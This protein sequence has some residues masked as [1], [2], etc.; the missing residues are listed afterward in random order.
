MDLSIIDKNSPLGYKEWLVH[1]SNILPDN[2]S[3]EY[4]LYL[5][6]WYFKNSK[7]KKEFSETLRIEYVQLLKDLSFLFSNDEVNLFISQLD[8]NNDEEII[9]AIP[10]FAKKLKQIALIYNK[11]RESL[12]ESKL[13]YNLA[14]SNYGIEKLLYDY[15]L[16]GFTKN[17]S[18]LIR[19]PSY[20]LYNSFP[21]L[22]SITGDFF[23]EIEELYDKNTYFDS[24][25]SL[26]ITDYVDV[27]RFD[28]RLIPE[29]FSNLSD[30]DILNIIS[31]KFLPK[32]ST[33][34]L[35]KI[36]NEFLSDIPNITS[37]SEYNIKALNFIN[38]NESSKKYLGQ[39]V[40]GLT[41]V[42]LKDVELYDKFINLDLNTGNNWFY[43]PS[44]DRILNDSIFNNLYSEILLNDSNLIQSGATGGDSYTN[45]DLIFTDKSGVVE[46]AWLRGVHNTKTEKR[47]MI[48][49]IGSSDTKEF[50]FPYPG[51]GFSPKT[52]KFNEYKLTDENNFLLNRFDSNNKEQILTDYFT[53]ILPTSSCNS[54]YLNNTTLISNG[55]YADT[56][57]DTADNIIKKVKTYNKLANYDEY[58]FG[59]V[60]QAYLYKFDKT[61]IIIRDGINNI[62]WPLQNYSENPDIKLTIGLDHSNPIN[63]SE[64][65][66]AKTMSGAVA[67]LD[68]QTGDVIYKLNTKNSDPIEA[69]WLGSAPISRLDT[70]VNPIKIY[71]GNATKC[72]EY[73]DGPIQPALSIKID[74]SEKKSFIWMDEDTYADDVF[75]NTEHLPS[76]PYVKN[77]PYDY[78]SDQDYQNANPLSDIKYW[79]KCNCKALQYS[80]IGHSGELVTDYNG[81]A[82][83]L[84][85]DPDGMGEDFN[86]KGWAD[87]RNLTYKNSPQFSFYKLDKNSKNDIHVGWGS[88]SWKTGNGSKMVLKTG[89]RYT[90]YRSTLRTDSSDTPYLITIYK[91]NKI[92]GLLTL[93]DGFDLVIVID[94]S[95]SQSLNLQTTKNCVKKIID[96]LLTNNTFENIQIG[97]ITFGF[98]ANNV[99]FLSKNKNSLLLSI[100]SIFIP[101]EPYLSE[102]DITKALV[103]AN[104][105]LTETII[106]RESTD[107]IKDLC[108]NLNFKIYDS[109]LGNK[110]FNVP[111]TNKPKKIL[112]FSDGYVEG[113]R[114]KDKN[115]I[116]YLYDDSISYLENKLNSIQVDINLTL[117]EEDDYLI[118]TQK[119]NQ[120][121]EKLENEILSYNTELSQ[122]QTVQKTIDD[123]IKPFENKLND[124]IKKWNENLLR[125]TNTYTTG[126]SNRITGKSESVNIINVRAEE[127]KKIIN[128]LSDISQN[129]SS[130]KTI[131]EL[132]SIIQSTLNFITSSYSL[133][134]KVI[135]GS[136]E[137][138]IE[139]FLDSYKSTLNDFIKNINYQT[140]VSLLYNDNELGIINNKI[141]DLKNMLNTSKSNLTISK[142]I[143]SNVDNT[144][145]INTS[146]KL[147]SE[148]L[149]LKKS[150]SDILE[151][152]NELKIF[153]DQF[154][155][156]VNTL[157]KKEIENLKKQDQKITFYT[158]DI[159]LKSYNT[160]IMEYM[161]ST[162]SNYFNLQKYLDYGDG[163]INSFISYMSMRLCG[164]IPIIPIWYK[165]KRDSFGSWIKCYDEIGNLEIS[166]MVLS[167]GDYLAYIHRSNISYYSLNNTGIDFSYSSISFSINIKLNGWDYENH[168]FS[169]F[170]TG[171]KYGAKPYWGEVQISPNEINNF[172]KETAS[173][174][175]KIKF[176]DDY[177]P[178]QQPNVSD[179][180]IDN[181]CVIE[182]VRNNQ[183]ELIWTQPLKCFD[184]DNNY[185]WNKL[186]FKKDISNLED[187]LNK[188]NLDG[189]VIESDQPS[190]LI[191][192]GYSS[193]KPVRYNYYSRNFFT[194]EQGLNIKNKC[195]DSFY[196]YNTGV[197]IEPTSPY[198][199]ILN[200]HFPTIATIPLPYD[201]VKIKDTGEYLLP[202]NLGVSY[203]R[204]RGYN[205]S[206]DNKS[207]DSIDNSN[208]E[209]FYFN[210]EKYGPRNRGLTKKDQKTIVK[211]DSIDNSWIME[212]YSSAEKSGT[213]INTLE[214]QKMIPYQTSYEIDVKN[215]YG[216]SR[217]DDNFKFWNP[218]IPA[219]WTEEDSFPLTY[220]KEL[221]KEVFISRKNKLL[222]DAGKLNKW[223][224]DIFGNDYGLYKK[225]TPKD[226]QNLELWFSSDYG[227]LSNDTL[228]LDATDG[229]KVVKWLNQSSDFGKDLFVYSGIPK[230]KHLGINE[231]PSVVFNLSSTTDVMKNTY[232]LNLNELTF[233]VIG[234]SYNY[235]VPLVECMVSFGDNISN[236]IP[237]TSSALTLSISSNTFGFSFGNIAELKQVDLN[238]Q[239][240]SVNLTSPHI[241][242]FEFKDSSC[243]SYIDGNLINSSD[244]ILTT[245]VY[246]NKGLF[247]GSYLNGLFKSSCEISEIILYSRVLN[248]IEKDELYKYI[249]YKYSIF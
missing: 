206:I 149:I 175:G 184:I 127:T 50:I 244:N 64:I 143:N 153:V 159:G 52:S 91:Y 132:K 135:G 155:I 221:T 248:N 238:S 113:A 73:F 224:M 63:L 56:F 36:F 226:I 7:T 205:I 66:I 98:E 188:Q 183:S 81:M 82:D 27:D 193:Y 18:N 223:K 218:E 79:Q 29:E 55:A 228:N 168:N 2:S 110:Y 169:S 10:F 76:C 167:P 93:N 34:I 208:L 88:G 122:L 242:E 158:V 186:I 243:F 45:S 70:E 139:E 68:F 44:G 86:L 239:T 16:K 202:H 54:I 200:T 111:Q 227:V 15:I 23:I 123:Y 22:S 38:L 108:S 118:A 126:K 109:A 46:G 24:D 163:D 100:D 246:S 162:Y 19:V 212:P 171:D 75:N 130:I 20:E 196:I 235:S 94:R 194:Y 99:S 21:E 234:K 42:K 191:L 101:D 13:K 3:N 59:E 51:V 133:Y 172:N 33:S 40:Y 80:P 192:E 31:T 49:R 112:F 119:Q 107:T 211:I 97:I 156:G 8:Y 161:S 17:E 32:S 14:G 26:K 41:A 1:N 203:Y 43:F 170:N 214:N 62:Y 121:L 178:I 220:R 231:L 157:V 229:E 210:L 207:L 195:L 137:T 102:T 47:E 115:N 104:K 209:R 151:A 144:Y 176:I 185:V 225:L 87:T 136:T 4:L 57:S 138:Y 5:K 146:N 114:T 78:Y 11:K 240:L 216:L 96:N 77:G 232:D 199:N 249:N 67:G 48:C 179:I 233:I 180:Y 166:D 198:K 134:E 106:D 60:K 204:G 189:I 213:I 39:S 85:A 95:K 165:A 12:K 236:T 230:Y 217:Q 177:L 65:N 61:D 245:N 145:F 190:D 160:D 120:E 148:Q 74:P 83:Y 37:I 197:V 128:H 89:R 72:A 147:Q 92:N 154:F 141:D 35:S 241:F 150:L 152:K 182:Y 116:D 131:S 90:Y 237:L 117:K 125:L 30:N 173:F 9:F 71:D 201:L 84:F 181:G 25:P 58:T 215:N 164:S 53:G 103:L 222:V 6:H 174:G 219:T 69:A 142:S 129:L 124:I 28:S 140:D 187:I 105:I 247:V